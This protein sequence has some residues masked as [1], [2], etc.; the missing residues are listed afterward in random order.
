MATGVRCVEQR[1]CMWCAGKRFGVTSRAQYIFFVTRNGNFIGSLV[2]S[3][4][5][6]VERGDPRLLLSE[7]VNG[8][9]YEI[10]QALFL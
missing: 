3:V 2:C 7:A 8:D 4:C 10:Y 9:Y 6:E 5:L 1:G